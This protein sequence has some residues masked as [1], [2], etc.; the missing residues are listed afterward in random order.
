MKGS[1]LL[2]AAL[3]NEGVE[4]IFGVPGEENLDVVESLR[5]SSIKLILTR[6]EQAA[7]FMAATYGRLTGKPGVCIDHARAGRAE[8]HHRR[9]LCLSRRDA[10]GDDHRPERH[11]E[12]PPGAVPDRRRGRRLQ[13][14]D[15]AVAPDRQPRQH[16]DAGA[17]RLPHRH[18]GAA[19]ARCCWNCRRTSPA[20]NDRAAADGPGASDRDPGGAP[21][22][23]GPRGRH[24][25]G[26]QAP[27]DHAGRR[28][29]R[30][31]AA[32]RASPASSAARRSRSSPRRWARARSPAAANLYMGT[33]AL[34]RARLRA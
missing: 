19:R 20:R 18:G 25:P 2:V 33:A 6:H 17:R 15:Q 31:R 1:D 16:P 34:S 7:A 13:A 30:A 24:D 28:R 9:R 5:G 10:D 8:P 26:G 14:A 3:E 32:P 27:A 12:Q 23:A 4:R 22:R 11:H 29:H 21:R